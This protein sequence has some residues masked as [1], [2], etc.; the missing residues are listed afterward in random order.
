MRWQSNAKKVTAKP[1]TWH[2]VNTVF[3]KFDSDKIYNR[4]MSH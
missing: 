2:F 3:E 1:S 4:L